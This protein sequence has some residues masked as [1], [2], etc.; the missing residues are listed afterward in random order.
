MW[1]A[2]S[3]SLEVLSTMSVSPHSHC[4]QGSSGSADWKLRGGVGVWEGWIE[5]G[6]GAQGEDRRRW[7]LIWLVREKDWA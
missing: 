4:S 6:A 1:V 5:G 3:G 2:A 7:R